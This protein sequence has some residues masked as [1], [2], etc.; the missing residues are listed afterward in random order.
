[1]GSNC[2]GRL[3]DHRLHGFGRDLGSVVAIADMR[4]RREWTGRIRERLR[5]E[6]GFTLAELLSAQV[7]G[8]FVMAAVVSMLIIT[9]NSSSR[10]T[11]R[12]NAIAQGRTAMEEIQQRLRSQT[13]MYQ[14][15]YAISPATQATGAVPSVVYAD[16]S[17]IVFFSDLGNAG[18]STAATSSVGFVPELRYLYVDPGPTGSKGRKAAFVDGQRNP[19]TSSIPFVFNVSPATSV[20]ALASTSTINSVTPST[21]RAFADGVTNDVSGTTT[22]PI[23]SYYDANGN[24]VTAGTSGVIGATNLASIAQV[25]VR[26]RVLGLS[27]KDSA[28]GGIT[29]AV[30]NRTASFQNAIYFKTSQ[31]SC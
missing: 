14:S 7:I 29:G 24:A 8:G 19:T 10:V 2:A 9:F 11:D 22:L 27:G 18:G 25:N 26:F 3:H 15:E 4:V 5:E 1:V 20:G 23:F 30:D 16:P 31:T 17:K 6:D 21:A 12:I 13:C 28:Q